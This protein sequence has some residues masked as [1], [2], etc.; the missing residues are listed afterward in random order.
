MNRNKTQK[1][2]NVAIRIKKIYNQMIIEIII[3]KAKFYLIL[4]TKIYSIHT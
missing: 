3:N 1:N 2:N 4:P